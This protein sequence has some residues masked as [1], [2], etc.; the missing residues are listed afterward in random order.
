M[1]CHCDPE[2]EIFSFSLEDIASTAKG[3]RLLSLEIEP[4]T[5]CNYLCPYCYS[6]KGEGDAAELD[7]TLIESVLRQAAE[8]GARR[9]VILGG[10]PLLYA[11]LFD[12]IDLINSLGMQAEIFSNG[13][14]LTPEIASRLF[15]ANVNLALKMNSLNS[16]VQERL[17]GVPAALDKA[18][19]ALANARAAGYPGEKAFLAVSSVISRANADG[20]VE[21]WRYLRENKITPYF[22]TITPQGRAKREENS[23][24]HLDPPEIREIFEKLSEADRDYGFKW[25]PQ[26]PLAGNRCLRHQ[27]SCLVNSR[28]EV[29][30]C[31][32]IDIAVGNVREQRLFDIIHDSEIIQD[33]RAKP[34]KEPCRSCEFS[35]SCYGC[36]GGAYQLTGDWRAADPQCW[37]NFDKLPQ[38]DVLPASAGRFIPHAGRMRLVDTLDLLGERHLEVSAEVRADNPFLCEDGTLPESA[39]LEYIAQAVAVDDGFSNSE[40]TRGMLVGIRDSHFIQGPPIR[41]G[42]RLRI[43]IKKL[44]R[45]ANFGVVRGEIYNLS[46]G[47]LLADGELK[48][49]KD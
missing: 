37:R 14:L 49:W 13:S 32:G 8:L 23:W 7:F 4:S 16:D 24:L 38:I 21:L 2:N 39:F 44:M 1:S 28:G 9:I 26:P 42:D 47:R 3:N 6:A 10:E 35:P 48:I 34:V 11:R 29:F 41:V 15:S 12:M 22:E 45:F 40:K 33:L 18:W 20:I 27:Y 25:R 30:P 43:K 19:A 31:V 46:D 36:R 17:S 5:R